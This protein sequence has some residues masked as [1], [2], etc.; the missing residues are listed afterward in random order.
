MVLKW[1]FLASLNTNNRFWRKKSCFFVVSSYLREVFLL[2]SDNTKRLEENLKHLLAR[3]DWSWMI[4]GLIIL[5]RIFFDF[6]MPCWKK[7]FWSSLGHAGTDIG[8]LDCFEIKYNQIKWKSVKTNKV[9]SPNWSFATQS[10]RLLQ[11][12]I[13]TKKFGWSLTVRNDR[14]S[15]YRMQSPA[16]Q[17]AISFFN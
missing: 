1:R 12:T 4:L 14:I 13:I 5:F 2:S 3:G 15:L 9:S 7:D 10:T 8:Q 11:T 16:G 17:K 6:I